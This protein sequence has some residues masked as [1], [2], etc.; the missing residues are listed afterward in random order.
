LITTHRTQAVAPLSLVDPGLVRGRGRQADGSLLPLGRYDYHNNEEYHMTTTTFQEAVKAALPDIN[1]N[2]MG[3]DQWSI[4]RS[5]CERPWSDGAGW[6]WSNRSSTI[7]LLDSLVKRGLAT[8]VDT[9]TN[10]YRRPRYTA[11]PE[12]SAIWREVESEQ[13]KELHARWDEQARQQKARQRVVSAKQHAA[14]NL[15][16]RHQAEYDALVEE[17]LA[18]HPVEA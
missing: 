3:D 1:T 18:S 6:T 17:Y 14:D 15:I 12:V 8:C 5:L 4:L 11:I 7:K 2:R 10:N 13:D 9:S 16:L